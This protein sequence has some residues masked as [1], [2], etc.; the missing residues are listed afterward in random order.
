MEGPLDIDEVLDEIRQR[1]VVEEVIFPVFF[2]DL[3]LNVPSP[4]QSGSRKDKSRESKGKWAASTA[5]SPSKKGVTFQETSESGTGAVS[6]VVG[7]CSLV[8]FLL[9][10]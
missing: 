6:V 7:R 2:V 4:A 9:T 5:G 10:F 8:C 1:D 3:V